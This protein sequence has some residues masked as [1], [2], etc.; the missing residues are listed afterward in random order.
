MRHLGGILNSDGGGAWSPGSVVM[1]AVLNTGPVVMEEEVLEP[2]PCG[3][4]GGR[5]EAQTRW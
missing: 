3:D 5:A 4:G 1:E 2:G